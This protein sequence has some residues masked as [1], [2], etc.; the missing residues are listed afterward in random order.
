M[1][2]LVKELRRQKILSSSMQEIQIVFVDKRQIRELN[3]R[4][5]KRD[6]PTD[7]LSFSGSGAPDLGE[8]VLC[9]EVLEKQSREHGLSLREELGYMLIHG[10]LHLLGYEHEGSPSQARRMFKLQD[11][12][13][14]QLRST[15]AREAKK[16]SVTLR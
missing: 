4:Y 16:A 11:A 8:L 9:G 1:A 15:K 12:L 5:R 3:S 7:I 10:T 2:K 13:F 6:K 14:D